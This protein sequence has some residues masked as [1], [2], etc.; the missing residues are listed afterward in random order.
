MKK[1]LLLALSALLLIVALAGCGASSGAGGSDS[2][3]IVLSHTAAPG[4]P[5]YLTYEKFKEEVEERSEGEVT[6]RIHHSAT[7]A[8]D[9][10]GVEMLKSNTLDVASA[11][12]NNM[13]PF[14]D[15]FLVFDLPYMFEDVYATHKVLS[16][17]IGQEFREKTRE[18]LDLELL[19][20]LDPGTHRHVMNT[21]R[22]VKVPD[23][24]KG[25]RFRSAESPIEMA[26]VESLGAIATPIT[27]VE[28]YSALEQGVVNG[29]VQQPHWAVTANLHEVIRHV[30]ETG[31]IHALHI[32][33]MNPRTF[34]GL[35]EEQQQ[36]VRD[37]ALAAQEFNFEQSPEF[38]DE[39][40][41]EMIDEGVTFYTPTEEE[42]QL[43]VETSV[44]IWDQFTDK[45]DQDLI[46]RIQAAQQ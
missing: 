28:V 43:W 22:E 17:E 31:G 44:K 26:Y 25:L 41:Q 19:F 24:L 5:I 10:Q 12:T 3:E 4:T 30:T 23:D 33:F 8:G 27:W 18:D 34:D 42:Q 40:K 9:T 35:T 7:L 11:A 29:L 20:F 36:I 6:V 13:A 32:A 15:L 38:A 21:E 37:A 39:L 1:Q 46:E 2:T 14:T 16:G 45:V